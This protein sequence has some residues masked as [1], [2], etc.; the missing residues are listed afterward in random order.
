[1]ASLDL[2]ALGLALRDAF[3][4]LPSITPVR[5]LGAGF[6][7]VNVETTGGLV[8]RIGRNAAA[9]E[10]HQM[11]AQLLPALA[12]HMPVAIPRPSWH[13]G[14]SSRFLFG[15]LGYPMLPGIPLAPQVLTDS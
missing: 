7:N 9:I 8:F 10:G 13:A 4:S 3:P 12:P 5:V 1:M 6:R 15:V 14:P 2:S 11:E